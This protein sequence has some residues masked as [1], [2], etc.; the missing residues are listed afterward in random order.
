[1]PPLHTVVNL[2]VENATLF[3]V[4]ANRVEFGPGADAVGYV[5]TALGYETT[6][7]GFISTAL[8]YL[9]TDGN[10]TPQWAMKP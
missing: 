1:M 9:T 8:G 10:F 7:N 2:L 3:D 5:S 4:S 6:A